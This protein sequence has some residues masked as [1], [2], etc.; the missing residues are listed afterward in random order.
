MGGKALNAIVIRSLYSYIIQ[1]SQESDLW[2][3]KEPAN[4]IS[5]EQ[6][7]HCEI[8]EGGRNARNHKDEELSQFFFFKERT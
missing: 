3:L 4:V 5:E 6:S 1:Q 8:L 7:F 2:M